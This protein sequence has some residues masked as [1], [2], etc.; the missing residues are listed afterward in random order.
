MAKSENKNTKIK[1]KKFVKKRKEIERTLVAICEREAR[2]HAHEI[3]GLPPLYEIP[4]LHG[5]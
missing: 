2:N 3:V 5:I 1:K 4:Q